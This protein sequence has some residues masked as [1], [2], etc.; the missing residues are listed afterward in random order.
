MCRLSFRDLCCSDRGEADFLAL[1]EHFQT[2]V[3]ERVPRFSSLEQSDTLKRFVK[4]LD[5]L[6]DRRVRLVLGAE[7]TLDELFEN[8]R[9]DIKSGGGLD[10]LAWRT[11]LYSADGKAGISASAVATL[12]EAV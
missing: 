10:D 2:I 1:A 6:Y 12:L 5:V 4:L 8:V 9:T 7:T 11:T 3:L